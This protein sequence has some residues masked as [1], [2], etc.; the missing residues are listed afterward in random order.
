MAVIQQGDGKWRSDDGNVYD[1]ETTARTVVSGKGDNIATGTAGTMIWFAVVGIKLYLWLIKSGIL[2]CFAIGAAISSTFGLVY[3]MITKI[4]YLAN[5]TAW[6]I[7]TAIGFAIS[8]FAWRSKK[9]PLFILMIAIGIP[10][11]I[12]AGIDKNRV[13]AADGEIV[14]TATAIVTGEKAELFPNLRASSKRIALLD[15]GAE[16]SIIGTYKRSATWTQVLY[17]DKK[18][19]I[20]TSL[21]KIQEE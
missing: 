7:T 14:I 1:D 11:L 15:K 5:I 12:S 20:E 6:F 18:L 9:K 17:E 2:P 10:G 16:V 3:T 21:I 4:P 13:E 19:W 8:F